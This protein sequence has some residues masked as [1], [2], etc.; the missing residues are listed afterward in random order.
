[1]QSSAW[2]WLSVT[3]Y[4][5]EVCTTSAAAKNPDTHINRGYKQCKYCNTPQCLTTFKIKT[6]T[7]TQYLTVLSCLTLLGPHHLQGWKQATGRFPQ[8]ST[9]LTNSSNNQEALTSLELTS[10]TRCFN[11]ADTH[12][13]NYP[14]LQETVLGWTLAGR[15]PTTTNPNNAQHAFILRDDNLE[16][17]WNRFWD[18]E[19]VDQST[20]TTEQKASED[21]FLTHTTQQPD[22]R[23]VVKLPT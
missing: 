12:P 16:N 8:T 18:V 23:F 6:Q 19:V 20:M 1:M 4:N 9:W 5:R 2:Q 10:S 13:G 11:R 22:G 7:G 14:V 15:T 3:F 21:H 17:K